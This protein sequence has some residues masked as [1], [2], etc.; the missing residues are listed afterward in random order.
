MSSAIRA[1]A[2]PEAGRPGERALLAAASAGDEHAF[3]S[4]TEPY[5]GAVRLHCYRMLGSLHDAEDAMQEVLLRAWR[6]LGS[7]R[8]DAT[9]AAWLYK[10]ATNTCLNALARRRRRAE[11]PLR[12]AA[13]PDDPPT[14]EI[15]WLEPFPDRLLDPA[16]LECAD[17][18]A[19][20]ATREAV[21]LAFI[22]S[23][24]HLPPRQRAVLILREALGWH[25][26]EVAELLE[27]SVPAVNSALQRARAT[28]EEK[29]PAGSLERASLEGMPEEGADLFRR[30]VDA[31]EQGDPDLLAS[32]LKED[33]V[34]V[35]PPQPWLSGRK[36]I[37]EFA[38]TGLAAEV[39]GRVRIIETRANAQPTFAAYLLDE[40]EGVYRA[41][42]IMVL[43][44]GD[45]LI[46]EITG[47]GDPTL[48]PFFGLPATL[49][50]IG[51]ARPRRQAPP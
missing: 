47:F 31:W 8:G 35:M 21:Q 9:F 42:G 43:G 25:A 28:L 14:A 39:L 16:D 46:A 32:L 49:E 1:G 18:A 5:A 51:Q 37:T 34:L 11:I 36:A 29:L 13:G 24:Q 48:F 15:P 27:T 44:V 23:L 45:G 41:Y 19:R 30:F 38:R 33:A 10:I 17:P 22:A 2:E 6:S 26:S 40:A 50:A 3:A 12:P 20:Y 4:L 7:F